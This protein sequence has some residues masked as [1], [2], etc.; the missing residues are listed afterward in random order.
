MQEHT[1][2][3]AAEVKKMM[4]DVQIEAHN[5]EIVESEAAEVL[6][7]LLFQ[8]NYYILILFYERDFKV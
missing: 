5:L 6:K 8:V 2:R 7:V 1:Y 4:E 3:C